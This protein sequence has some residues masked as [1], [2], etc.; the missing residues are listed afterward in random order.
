M[1]DRTAIEWCDATWNPITGCSPC[2]PGCE[3]C[4]AKRMAE[5]FPQTH[6]YAVGGDCDELAPVPFE[7]V[8]FHPDRL[9]Q[10]SRWRKPRRI[11]VCSMGDLFHPHV[12][13]GWR[14]VV[15][16][17]MQD[18]DQHT[19]MVLTKRPE[20]M[21]YWAKNWWP[22]I[23]PNVWLGVTVCNQ[24]EAD[25]KIPALLRTPAERRFVS[26]EP[27]LGPVS[28][29]VPIEGPGTLTALDLLDLVIVGGETGPG[30]RPMRHE[31]ACDVLDQCDAAGVSFFYKGAG[32]NTVHGLP[33]WH[34][35]YHLLDG[36]EWHERPLPR[37]AKSVHSA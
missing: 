30:A 16:G 21:E 9:D 28:L 8:L 18:A 14:A 2:S 3:H 12:S 35:G 23:E 32:T 19:F 4:Y 17:E 27:M 37:T 26:I 10:P 24:A 22:S 5:R 33:K 29:G 36:R 20:A 25:A 1:G 6:G 34:P 11:F 13:N 31:W 7:R 15:F